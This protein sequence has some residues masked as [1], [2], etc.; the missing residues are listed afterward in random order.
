MNEEY[1]A[2][3]K[4]ND[5]DAF[6]PAR[7]IL[8]GVTLRDE[9]I[10]SFGKDCILKEKTGKGE[11][12]DIKD[13]TG[14]VQRGPLNY[15]WVFCFSCNCISHLYC[16]GYS[17]QAFIDTVLEKPFRCRRCLAEPNNER[18]KAF[19]VEQFHT[20]EKIKLRRDV[21]TKSIDLNDTNDE[22][23]PANETEDL[24]S[25][26]ADYEA[27][28]KALSLRCEK[29]ES[30]QGETMVRLSECMLQLQEFKEMK[31]EW[32][33][34]RAQTSCGSVKPSTDDSGRDDHIP[35]SIQN[36]LNTSRR[37]KTSRPPI[38]DIEC[39]EPTPEMISR[40]RS[41]GSEAPVPKPR[42]SYIDNINVDELTRT[43]RITLEQAHAQ[44][45]ATEAQREI[46]TSQN[47]TVIRKALPRITKF[48]GD[49]RKW[50]QFKRDIDRYRD[51]GKY[52]DYEM[53]IHILQAL[54]G[55][56]LSRVQGSIDSVPFK[57]TM[58]VL[59]KCFGEPTRIIDK[60]AKDI[61]GL[62]VPRDLTKDDVL[63]ITSK[64]LDYFGAC[65]YANVDVLNSN[66]LAMHIFNQ[67]S[68]LHKQLYRHKI[69]QENVGTSS[70]VVELD[71]L[72]EF[73]EELA[74]EL[75]DK[76]LDDKK[77]E[78]KKYK[79]AQVN[80]HAI[81]KSSGN[82]YTK[83]R[84]PDDYMFEVK[85]SVGYDMK[86]L[87]KI[88][89]S[90]DCCITN[91]HFTVQC[92]NYRVMSV[93]ERL[94]FVNE[95]NICRNCLITSTHRA[96]NCHL[97][98]PC[99][100]LNG[101]QKCSRKHHVSLHKAFDNYESNT[102]SHKNKGS[103][104]GNGGSG[105]G[106]YGRPFR[107]NNSRFNQQK[108]DNIANKFQRDTDK[109]AASEDEKVCEDNTN[110]LILQAPKISEMPSKQVGF[111][112]Q[113]SIH[114]VA[115]NTAS[116]CG[117][118]ATQ[119]DQR[120]VKVFK[121]KFFGNHGVIEGYSLG[122]SAAEATLLCEELREMLGIEGEKCELTLQWTDGSIKTVEATRMD[123]V[124]QGC[125]K[126]CK[127]LTLE[128]CYAIPDL[129]LPKRSL[130]M[131]KLKSQF[132]YLR[133]ID[134][135][136]YQNVS[137]SLLI[138]SP[139]ASV[140]EST[141]K[142]LEGGEGKPVGLRAKLG[143]SVYGGSM[144]ECDL[145]PYNIECITT[146]V[147][148]CADNSKISNEKLLELYTYFC[149]IESL[150]IGH[151]TKH[152]TQKEQMA[153]SILK[154][155]MRILSNGSVQ[156]PLVWNLDGNRIPKLPNNFIMVYKRQ[157]SHEKKLSK[158]PDHLKA[159]NDNFK[160]W[161]KDG[162]VRPASSVDLDS[163]W[164]NVSYLPMTLTCNSNKDPPKFRNVFDASAR[165]NGSSLNENLLKGPDL[166]VDLTKPL[167]RMRENKIAFTADIKNMFM[168]MKVCMRDQQVQ[169][170]MWR[171]SMN[172]EFRIFVFTSMLFGPTSS[173][174]TSQWVKNETAERFMGI[175]P[176]A[177]ETIKSYMYMDDLLTSEKSLSE[178]VL[179]AKQCIKIFDSMNWKLIQF[180]S[181][182]VNFLKSLPETNAR[183][184]IIPLLE[185]DVDSC[186][187]KVLGCVWDTKNDAFV[188][189]FDKNMFIQIVKEC[190]HRP[191][192]RDQCSTI[193]RIF[194]VLGL[195]SPFIIRGKILLQRSWLAGIGWDE[196]ISEKDHIEWKNWLNEIENVAKVKVQRQFNL[197]NNLSECETLELHT[198]A[199][200]GGEAFAAVSYIVTTSNNEIFSNIVMAKAKIT[201]IRHKSR[202]QV[203]EMPRLELCACLIASRLAATITK[204]FA[205]LKF[206]RYFWTDSE[207]VLRWIVNPNH[208]LLKY[209]ISPI[210]EILDK[211]TRGEWRYVPTKLNVA[212]IATKFKRFDFSDSNSVWFKGPDFLRLP[213]SSWPS[214]P[215]FAEPPVVH[216]VS[217]NTLSVCNLPISTH[218]LPTV[219]C[220]RLNETI[221]DKFRPAI[222]S[223][224]LKLV[225][226]TAR[227]LK[228]VMDGLGPLAK[229]G[230]IESMKVR[231]EIKRVN[232]SFA[233]LSP[234][235]KERAEHFIIRKMQRDTYPK[236]YECLRLKRPI[237]NR[238]LLQL[239]VF[240]DDVGLMRIN[241]RVEYG[242]VK[243]SPQYAPLMPRNY[244]ITR[245]YLMYVHEEFKHI[246]IETQIG[247][248]R[249]YYW[250]P[251][252]R[253][254]LKSIQFN[255]N[256][257]RLLR[258]K[259]IAPKM[260]PLPDCRTNP[261][262]APFQTTGL[263]CMGPF[264]IKN[265]T[266]RKKVWV[267]IF[268][269][270]LTRF[271]HLRILDSLE[272]IKVLEAIVEFWASHGPV[273]TFISDRGTN[274]V[275]ASNIIAD[276]KKL[277]EK[278]LREQRNV[279]SQQLV[280][281]YNVEWK[282]LP[283]H[284]PW[285]GG[286]YERLI[287]EVKR[288]IAPVLN[289]RELT[290]PTLN[291]ALNDAA[292]RINNRPLTHNS[293]SAEDEEILTPHL[294]AKGR[295]GWPYLPG[296]QSTSSKDI[297]S[298]R[299]TYRR[300][301]AV[302]DEM[303]RRFFRNYLPT[304]TKRV[305]WNKDVKPIK[306][307]DLVLLIE[308]ND[309]RSE[310]KRAKVVNVYKGRD[311]GK[312]VADVMMPDRTIKKA[313][314]VQR[315]ARIEIHS[316]DD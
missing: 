155:E 250:V 227:A 132:P 36:L 287:K 79:P 261:T 143:F 270:T 88:N 264:I 83:A 284:S 24:E 76:R 124:I 98:T 291:I 65:I 136:S 111:I 127:K 110:E 32:D 41:V 92:R 159:F 183:Q 162:Y 297:P 242:G 268:V 212:D 151:K 122:D 163:N 220:P 311:K 263:D 252:L 193:A 28:L 107:R 222:R 120:T 223:R 89:K 5:P 37:N 135:E 3:L 20:D 232:E 73:L 128:N 29:A 95:K 171:E 203:S 90:C 307:G 186:V 56:A 246:H 34:F 61:L 313:R 38:N 304:L 269:C 141:G 104:N 156:V 139:H 286:F 285:M 160:N 292:H 134:F 33:K 31:R 166:L 64:I 30:A 108:A 172:D 130:D 142:L 42:K 253:A 262:G 116:G 40:G 176:K 105:S 294:L 283:A 244:P 216:E 67:L 27:K 229:S 178:A 243:V 254:A 169:R 158:N 266:R 153:L 112:N 218:R 55:L 308:P 315:L 14:K 198:F 51:I 305:K 8:K 45:E 272:S 23:K 113:H 179:V 233:V 147:N 71:T 214:L 85:E 15:S 22:D 276:D 165:Y 129:I 202:T 2:G 290:A 109:A 146:D 194:D 60:Y 157:L 137:P 249:H 150:G 280:D 81:G 91:G 184:E 6:L 217:I 180:Q 53:R 296:V 289:S 215:Q 259:P 175:Y 224:W 196:E 207:V 26:K 205:H 245:A 204:H 16:Q 82:S 78:E 138:G 152:L 46:A 277:T 7:Y 298:D 271:I 225:R 235:D 70:H 201:P 197:T 161:L 306:A 301:R 68:L 44:M 279:L 9:I 106:N 309:T 18:A 74:D 195:I 185:S 115:A 267:L 302:A 99:G 148:E 69:K 126:N 50:I 119:I 52:D 300:G 94:R 154:K 293:V 239:S 140:F 72:F 131:G 167:L 238:E 274:F 145:I 236:E 310:W 66:N 48:N 206:K 248:V 251:Q 144:N 10:C 255:C 77:P 181:N 17:T 278:F 219:E 47:L 25:I 43:E 312:R 12:G 63:V 187:T 49:P 13:S 168:Q 4:E 273:K 182:D 211:T 125:S 241:S 199:D 221:I 19:F 299:S 240:L 103:G 314:S 57:N 87:I 256:Y 97:K 209:A 39:S 123:L 173:P 230:K 258:A 282:L 118:T 80:M 58:S 191:T 96:F 102:Y 247:Y 117:S 228:I 62:K 35:S 188:F 59:Q 1:L 213:A 190:E 174:F 189:K 295:S 281:K 177:A 234:A 149:S 192:K 210:E 84:L 288:S 237:S 93:S 11:L 164:P 231:E 303:M 170:I 75:E 265:Y 260:A 114:A 226:A 121:N 54:E 133:D 208:K 86:E 257:C 21:F 200:A 316:S 275:G 101:N 100:F